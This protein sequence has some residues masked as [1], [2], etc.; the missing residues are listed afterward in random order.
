MF[1]WWPRFW[2]RFLNNEAYFV[3][4]VRALVMGLSL[5]GLAFAK[6]M[7]D[8][9]GSPAVGKWLKVLAVVCGG[10]ALLMRAG[11]KTPENVKALAEKLNGRPEP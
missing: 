6:D 2:D 5:G 11:D 1:T 8:A 3:A 10:I 7:G 4:R 9:L